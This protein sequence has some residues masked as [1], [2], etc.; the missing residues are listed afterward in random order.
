MASGASVAG[1]V[2]PLMISILITQVGF[3]NAVRCM[4][5]VVTGTAIFAIIFARPNPAAEIRR[6]EKWSFGAF[7]DLHA[8]QNPAFAW[9][10]AAISILFFGFYAVFFNLESWAASEGL[11]YRGEA[12]SSIGLVKE[13]HNDAI[14]TFY[15]LCIMNGTSL[16]GRISSAYFCDIFGA[17]N[18]HAIVTFI[19]ALLVLLLW[20]MTHTVPAAVCFVVFFGIF[21]GA[22][23]GLPPA[24]VAYILGPNG[25]AKLGQWTGM[26]YTCAAI[27]ALTGPVIA[28]HLITRF[29]QNFL[30]VQLWS[31]LCLFLSACCMT[32]AIYY[33][34]RATARGA[35]AATDEEMKAEQFAFPSDANTEVDRSEA[36]STKDEKDQSQP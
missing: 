20:T 28:G 22:V 6:P 11:G 21:S 33:R 19:G 16:V 4:A 17:L 13:V 24:S 35:K 29:D 12:P 25:Q 36:V 9:L 34:R 26:M 5:A 10:C 27:S 3:N 8:F 30:T 2:Y 1:L 23:I 7:V 14:R 18:V 31:G 15:L 32:M